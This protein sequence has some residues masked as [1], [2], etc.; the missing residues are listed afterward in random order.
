MFSHSSMSVPLKF[1][2]SWFQGYVNWHG[3]SSTAVDSQEAL[4]YSDDSESEE[5]DEE[6]LEQLKEFVCPVHGRLSVT[7]DDA[8]LLVK[9]QHS[10]DSG[11][12]NS[13]ENI[14]KKAAEVTQSKVQYVNATNQLFK[15]HD[16]LRLKSADSGV[17]DNGVNSPTIP[18][19]SKKQASR[20]DSGMPDSPCYSKTSPPYTNI[21][22]TAFSHFP[23][24]SPT[25]GN[26]YCTDPTSTGTALNRRLSAHPDN[27]PMFPALG[28]EESD[29]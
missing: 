9:E 22:D 29:V 25:G 14:H 15:I 26:A 23:P 18:T 24:L 7:A 4:E 28:I 16:R 12:S 11:I 27:R 3:G 19:C 20:V 2:L 10:V 6:K 8:K 5:G 21:S 17:G 1:N 13:T